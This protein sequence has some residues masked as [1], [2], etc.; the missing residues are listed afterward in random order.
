MDHQELHDALEWLRHAVTVAENVLLTELA[1]ETREEWRSTLERK[2]A[3]LRDLEQV[4][5][6][7]L[8]SN[9]PAAAVPSNSEAASTRSAAAPA[10]TMHV[11]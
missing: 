4:N 8:V 2:R 10:G 7:L 1:P 3:L 9:F 6:S 5:D 11:H